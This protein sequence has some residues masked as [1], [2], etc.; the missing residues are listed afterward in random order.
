M[1]HILSV[2]PASY[3]KGGMGARM[4]FAITS[5]PLG[6]LMVTAT[7]KGVCF[8]SLG[9]DEH[10][11]AELHREYPLAEIVTDQT[12]VLGSHISVRHVAP[13]D[14]IATEVSS[15]RGFELAY[16]GMTVGV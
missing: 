15:R 2:T 16:D 14:D 7:E 5:S 4:G 12:R 10:L 1:D 13:H 9:E 11:I 8:L 6:R 3:A